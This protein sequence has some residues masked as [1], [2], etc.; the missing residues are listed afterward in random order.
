L[1]WLFWKWD[2]I[3]PG[4]P[5]TVILPIVASQ[6]ARITGVSHQHLLN[7]TVKFSLFLCL[8]IWLDLGLN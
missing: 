3:Y 7:N 6:V 5:Q 2:T 1:L 8:L 4:R